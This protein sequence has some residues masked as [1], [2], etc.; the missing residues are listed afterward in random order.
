[1]IQEIYLK[2]ALNIRKEYNSIVN[3]VDNYEKMA[4]KL[5]SSIE[6]R[7]KD[8][9]SLKEK[10]ESGKMHDVESAKD[11]LMKI[12]ISLEEEANVIDSAINSMNLRIEG[13]R[14]EESSLYKEIKQ[15]YPNLEDH[16]IKSQVHKYLVDH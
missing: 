7:G 14:S 8:L 1:M 16:D 2:K 4:Y 3:K 15:S 5:I 12:I 10:I 6:E 13:L 9:V 11:E